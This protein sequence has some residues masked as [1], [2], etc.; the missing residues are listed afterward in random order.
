MASTLYL[1]YNRSW[2]DVQCLE[3]EQR[4]L[5]TIVS[6]F[7]KAKKVASENQYSVID[8]VEVDFST[9]SYEV[10]GSYD[11]NGNCNCEYDD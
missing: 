10:V 8:E 6:D 4:T 7:E 2:I 3:Y 11:S 5:K 9:G 1:I